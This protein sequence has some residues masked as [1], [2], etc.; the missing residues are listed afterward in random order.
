MK[1]YSTTDHTPG[2]PL[3]YLANGL[4]GLRLQ[5][6]PF[7]RGSALVNG[8]VG[9]S[10]EKALEE[11]AEVPWPLGWD[12][13]FGPVK[14][15]ERPGWVTYENESYDFATGEHRVRFRIHALAG[16]LR[17]EVLTY[18]SRT[19]PTLVIQETTF[20]TE[21]PVTF[22]FETA[23]ELRGCDGRLAYQAR[24]GKGAEGAV[25][26]ESRGA[27]ARLGLAYATQ[28]D[29]EFVKASRRNNFGHEADRQL[30]QYTLA[31]PPNQPCRVRHLVSLVPGCLH[32]EPHWQAYRQI[33]IG[34][35]HG[36][37]ELQAAN[38]AAWAE[39]WKGRVRITA[40]DPVFQE[41]ADAAFFYLHSSVHPASPCSVA[42]YGLGQ[43]RLY[44]GHVFWDCETF[45]F[46]PALF[47]QPEAAKAMLEYRSRCLPRARDNA[48][49]NGYRGIQ[50]P[51]Q[52]GL[53]GSEVTTYYNAGGAI[54]HHVNLDVA[55]AFAQYVHATGDEIIFKE[56]A[57]P[58]LQGVAEWIVSRVTKTARGYEIRHVT[59]PDEAVDN[60]HNDVFT[61]AAAIVILREAAGF[62]ERLGYRA[63][64]TWTDVAAKMF[65]P[66][67]PATQVIRQHD[68]YTY[69]G[70]MCHPS[71]MA[72]YF[73]F[74][75]RHSSA[76]DEATAH[77]HMRYAETYLGMPMHSANFAVWACQWGE[78]ALARRFIERGVLTH[79]VEPFYMFNEVAPVVNGGI[80]GESR[81]DT[82]FLTTPA[83]Y[84]MTLI[85]GFPAL[86]LSAAEPALWFE[87]EVVL[88]EGWT[89]IAV[90]RLFVRGE[91]RGLEARQGARARWIE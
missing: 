29:A 25:L 46:P 82:V 90:E 21:Q 71:V 91:A 56:H 72:A 52:S 63:P 23:I 74:G 73:P 43:R 75:Y 49:V 69:D 61:N 22:Q 62:A 6:L 17:V 76:V 78:R 80:L 81:D 41:T 84:L 4:I 65:I 28:A 58:V 38:R 37:E 30:T 87:R 85:M 66:I 20:T 47:Q 9:E 42:P 33:A 55:L 77:F 15:S 8:F 39:L 18:C 68:N 79:R 7:L 3:A 1:T 5:P 13:A 40:D 24:P 70:G 36:F 44:S 88:P 31:L 59:G 83:G 32:D 48:R 60:I 34:L 86:Q 64:A 19:Q 12:C 67:D 27:R 51:W 16:N 10:P 53:T 26:W 14:L 50:F 54:E 89:E 57:W 2:R 11:S 35:W 45:M